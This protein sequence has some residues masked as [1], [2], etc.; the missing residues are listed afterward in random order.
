MAQL[1][2]TA[3]GAAC[4][5]EDFEDVVESDGDEED[6]TLDYGA[7]AD[8]LAALAAGAAALAIDTAA[9]TAGAAAATRNAAAFSSAGTAAL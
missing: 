2:A 8:E 9:L 1:V 3:G 7:A 4:D 5:N 6:A